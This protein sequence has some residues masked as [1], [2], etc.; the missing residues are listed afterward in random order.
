MIVL[1]RWVH[2]DISGFEGVVTGKVYYVT[3]CQQVLVVSQSKD[4]IESGNSN[5]LDV[6]RVKPIS[7]A[8]RDDLRTLAEVNGMDDLDN[9]NYT[10]LLGHEAKDIVS[11]I[12]GIITG[13]CY[14]IS[15]EIELLI[16]PKT[17]EATKATKTH[18][19]A[20]G[21]TSIGEVKYVIP[22]NQLTESAT[23][24]Q[25][26]AAETVAGFGDTPSKSY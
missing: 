10:S 4:G 3:G 26:E 18:W 2:D 19:V 21:R 23:K 22:N 16:D 8:Y 9:K 12:K 15:G 25:D 11:R 13:V 5:W 7:S 24:P 6:D 1:G 14:Y 17:E 20:R